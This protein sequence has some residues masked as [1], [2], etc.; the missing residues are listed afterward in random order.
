MFV[1]LAPRGPLGKSTQVR[2]DVDNQLRDLITK[3]SW[4][5]HQIQS[6][7]RCYLLLVDLSNQRVHDLTIQNDLDGT[8]MRLCCT[9]RQRP[10]GPA[11]VQN[12]A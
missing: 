4:P 2:I 3:P 12:G 1:G 8:R 6:F 5:S 10:G 11:T 7:R 9:R